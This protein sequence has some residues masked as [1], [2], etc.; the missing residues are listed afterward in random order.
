MVPIKYPFRICSIYFN[1]LR[2]CQ[3]KH[4]TVFFLAYYKCHVVFCLKVD[5]ALH[6]AEHTTP[7]PVEPYQKIIN[8]MNT[9]VLNK[10][11]SSMCN[12]KGIDYCAVSPFIDVCHFNQL[13]FTA[14]V[15]NF[16]FFKLGNSETFS[17]SH[18]VLGDYKG[19][20]V[21]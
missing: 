2:D 13:Q 19:A 6:S 21:P 5:E 20:F 11:I 9:A 1:Q 16:I 18:Y 12:H 10:V 4:E 17:N 3:N 7:H 8:Y 15:V 14:I